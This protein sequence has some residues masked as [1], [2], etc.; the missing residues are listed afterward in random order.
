MWGIG[1]IRLGEHQMSVKEGLEPPFRGHF[2]K[3]ISYMRMQVQKGRNEPGL[4][5]E[6]VGLESKNRMASV[7]TLSYSID[8]GTRRWS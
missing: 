8:I 4:M 5:N 7:K 1:L 2:L 6:V 3:A